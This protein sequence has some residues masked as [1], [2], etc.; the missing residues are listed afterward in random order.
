MIYVFFFRVGYERNSSRLS[1]F[2]I[3][4]TWWEH[5]IFRRLGLAFSFR[6][7]VKIRVKV[8][9]KI[10]VRV[11]VK[12]ERRE[13]GAGRQESRRGGWVRCVWCGWVFVL[14]GPCLVFALVALVLSS[15]LSCLC[16]C[17]VF[18]L[19]LS[20]SLALSFRPSLVLVL[21]FILV[22]GLA[23]GSGRT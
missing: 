13:R 3:T 7:K 19:V 11:R 9:L 16:P 17:L 8:E 21:V 6:V 22:L 23:S 14:L 2:R 12:R 10:R 18:A 5:I 15:P 4:T 20:W 1:A